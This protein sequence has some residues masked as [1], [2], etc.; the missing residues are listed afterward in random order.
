L[1]VRGIRGRTLARRIAVFLGAFLLFTSL[2]FVFRQQ[3][4]PFVN[5]VLNVQAG[6]RLVDVL[7]PA[8]AVRGHGDRIESATTSIQ[9]SQ[10][11]EGVDVMFMFVAAMLATP[12]AGRR[13]LVGC[14]VG[15]GV[16]YVCNLL[17][18]AGLWY[19]LKY[20]PERFEAMHVVVGQTAIIVVAVAVFAGAT[21]LFA[22]LREAT[23]P[24]AEEIG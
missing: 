7:T 18:L 20:A 16:I 15:I 5:G 21:G 6:A 14:V 22:R 23:A 4:G 8:E 2:E 1:V 13:K 3:V 17:R 24:P 11:C 10:G 9:V 12:M 19:C